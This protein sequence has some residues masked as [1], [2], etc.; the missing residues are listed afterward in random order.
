YSTGSSLPSQSWLMMQKE[1]VGSGRID[2]AMMNEI[3]DVVSRFPGVY[4]NAIGEMIEGLAGNGAYQEL[5]QIPGQ[6]YV[7]L[8]LPY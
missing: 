6:V 5:R 1:L 7:Q 4:N 3:G 8:A 2:Q